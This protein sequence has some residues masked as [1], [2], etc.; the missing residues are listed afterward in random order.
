MNKMK[1]NGVKPTRSKNGG[2]LYKDYEITNHGYYPPD[3]CVWWEA[4]NLKTGNAD[5]HANTK[6]DIIHLIDGIKRQLFIRFKDI[7]EDEISG[8]YDGDLGKIR[9]EIGVSCYHFIK[10][11]ENYNIILSSVSPGFLSDLS[12]FLYFGDNLPIYLIEAEQVGIGSCGEPVVKNI[13]ILEQLE[14]VELVDP[15]P[16][17][18]MDVTNPQLRSAKKHLKNK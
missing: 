13:E 9:E 8:V 10:N 18:K 14:V 12:R 11:G 5:F 7:P 2:Y 4:V 6:R 15:K 1:A 16:K 17:F 3:K